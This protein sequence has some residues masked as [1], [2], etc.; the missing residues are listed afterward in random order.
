VI[1]NKAINSI[2]IQNVSQNNGR[3]GMPSIS[4]D[5]RT[6]TVPIACDGKGP[7]EGRAWQK[8]VVSGVIL[9]VP[10]QDDLKSW[11]IQCVKCTA[12]KNCP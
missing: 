2:A 8:I 12:E 9:R 3:Y 10:S 7:G 5:G 11:V 4:A 1:Q 6:V